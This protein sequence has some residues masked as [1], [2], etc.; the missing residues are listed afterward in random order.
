MH[1]TAWHQLLGVSCFGPHLTGPLTDSLRFLCVFYSLPI[2][3]F[4]YW[5]RS[6]R[7]LSLQF[8]ATT[9]LLHTSAQSVFYLLEI[10]SRPPENATPQVRLFCTSMSYGLC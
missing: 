5:A 7:F 4:N 6:Q 9:T 2:V 8:D 3:W 1:G 10:L